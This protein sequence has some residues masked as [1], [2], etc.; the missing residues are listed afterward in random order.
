MALLLV[1]TAAT[2]APEEKT[3]KRAFLAGCDAATIVARV[4]ALET[5]SA[6]FADQSDGAAVCLLFERI[7]KVESGSYTVIENFVYRIRDPEQSTA[8]EHAQEFAPKAEIEAAGVWVLHDG[9]VTPGDRASVTIVEGKDEVPTTVLMAARDVRAGDVV[10]YS[11]KY[12]VP[13]SFYGTTFGMFLDVPVHQAVLMLD[14]DSCY[15]FRQ[16]GFN[17]KKNQWRSEVLRRTNNIVTLTRWTLTDSPAVVRGPLSPPPL[18]AGPAIHVLFAGSC[19]SG[20]GA[21]DNWN[22]VA[23]VIDR[24]C[25]RLFA[26]DLDLRRTAIR[27][28]DGH[29]TARARMKALQAFVRDRIVIVDR[30]WPD[31]FT[32]AAE[33]LHTRTGSRFQAGALLYTMA[34][35]AGLNV[36][37]VFA[38]SAYHGP[39]DKENYGVPQFSDVVVELVDEPGTY[40]CVG[41]RPGQNGGLTPDLMG[42]SALHVMPGIAAKD[43]EFQ[44]LAWKRGKSESMA[45]VEREYRRLVNA[46]TFH[47]L[48]EL[49]GD[50]AALQSSLEEVVSLDPRSGDL[51]LTASTGNPQHRV[52]L[53]ARAPYGDQGARSYWAWRFPDLVAPT[54]SLLSRADTLHIRAEAIV[55]AADG[56]LI[57]V[58]ADVAYGP[59]FLPEWP[60]PPLR[61]FHSP[62]TRLIRRVFR[63][64]VPPGYQVASHPEPVTFDL[65]EVSIRAQARVVGD[66]LVIVREFIWRSSVAVRESLGPL[67]QA[68]TAMRAFEQ[69]PLMIARH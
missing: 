22:R 2:A 46:A 65:P 10:G 1:S 45:A 11:L 56:D 69:T 57:T 53:S 43:E 63:L 58:P 67:E 42:V 18:L 61:S 47:R 4:A 66:E 51:D 5:V 20:F 25:E 68:F 60:G 7:Y 40:F 27:Q 31:W 13:R 41:A 16:Y 39:F 55:P 28:A 59:A 35:E 62:V 33:L 50:P 6:P 12:A 17:L 34:R 15:R 49:P 30:D 23:V 9:I 8:T 21:V 3:V 19:R 44:N 36:R 52:D 24:W 14:T 26:A 29:D 48:F 32:S 64:R 37:P 38:Q 54:D